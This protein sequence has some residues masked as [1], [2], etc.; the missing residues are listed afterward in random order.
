MT[1]GQLE[2]EALLASNVNKPVMADVW[3]TDLRKLPQISGKAVDDFVKLRCVANE[4]GVRGYKF[5]LEQ[6]IHD[7]TG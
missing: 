2:N 1:L 7:V 5:F 3:H 4:T 6:Y